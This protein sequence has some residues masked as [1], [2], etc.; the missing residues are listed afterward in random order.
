MI[1]HKLG[2]PRDS[3]HR[4]SASH[5]GTHRSQGFCGLHDFTQGLHRWVVE[6]GELAGVP[7]V[8][9]GTWEID[10]GSIG[11]LWSLGD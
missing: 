9:C 3:F 8:D 7:L 6:P 1:K 11:R 4:D 2:F 10:W 5:R